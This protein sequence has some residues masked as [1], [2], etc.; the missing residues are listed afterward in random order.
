MHN[1][2][3]VA[4]AKKATFLFYVYRVSISV[5]ILLTAGKGKGS[6][7]IVIVFSQKLI[8]FRYVIPGK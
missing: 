3:Y 4:G 7:L 2:H 5:E 8:L 6:T 1:A